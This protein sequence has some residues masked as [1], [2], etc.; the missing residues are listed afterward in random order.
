MKNKIIKESVNDIIKRL[1]LD[2]GKWEV[3]YINCYDTKIK[4]K[5]VLN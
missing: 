1:K 5:E 3:A 4:E 2:S